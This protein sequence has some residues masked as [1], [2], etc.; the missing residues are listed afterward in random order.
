MIK[1]AWQLQADITDIKTVKTT[2]TWPF[3]LKSWQ[4]QEQT[5]PL[6]GSKAQS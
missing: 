5:T 2:E 1:N 6:S 3:T 4:L